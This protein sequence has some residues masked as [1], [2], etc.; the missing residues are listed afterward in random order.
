LR[1]QQSAKPFL[2]NS[3]EP[4]K[5][6]TTAKVLEA[7]A[8]IDERIDAQKIQALDREEGKEISLTTA[9]INYMVRLYAWLA[10]VHAFD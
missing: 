3:V 7:I 10:Y 2:P 1:N 6:Q 5:A 8:K 4:K 9:R